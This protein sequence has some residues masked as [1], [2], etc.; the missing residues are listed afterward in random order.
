M[1]RRPK[2]TQPFDKAITSYIFFKSAEGLSDRSIASYEYILGQCL[3]R[4]GPID[5]AAITSRDITEHIN[6]LRNEYVP[7]R[8]GGKTHPLSP[9]TLRNVWIALSSFFAWAGTEY[10]IENPVKDVPAPRFQ[11]F[12]V[13]IFTQDDVRAMLKAC[14]YAKEAATSARKSFAFRRPTAKRDSAILL[15]LLDTGVR[16]SELCAMTIGDLDIKLGKLE[17]KHGISGGA[18]GG[19]GRT[20]YLGKVSRQAVWRYLQDREDADDQEAPLFVVSGIRPLRPNALLRLVKRIGERASVPNVYPHK[21]RHTFAITYLRSGGDVFT[22]QSLLGHG[23]L[24]MVRYYAQI[25]QIDVEQ[26]HRKAS[27]ADNWRL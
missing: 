19:K 10:G 4:W 1:K 18:K 24:D 17:I 5:I 12:T 15:V 26:A 13:T 25:A 22:L 3:E 9:K 6:W 23:S 2:S 14:V 20:V 7:R 16:A 27:P 8:Y 11:K 21:F